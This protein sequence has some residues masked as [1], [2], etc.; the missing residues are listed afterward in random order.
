MNTTRKIKTPRS[1]I[2]AVFLQQ[3]MGTGKKWCIHPGRYRIN[4]D[5]IN[6]LIDEIETH[7]FCSACDEILN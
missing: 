6:Y 5:V 3:K 1:E 4:A 2:D 7:E